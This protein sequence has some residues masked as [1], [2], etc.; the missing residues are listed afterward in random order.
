MTT[1]LQSEERGAIDVTGRVY[2]ENTFLDKMALCVSAILGERSRV[3]R[4]SMA[5]F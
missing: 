3:K 2:A 1:I 5:A 4:S